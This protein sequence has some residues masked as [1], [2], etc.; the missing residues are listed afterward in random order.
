MLRSFKLAA[1]A[2]A[3]AAITSAPNAWAVTFNFQSDEAN[4][5]E[6]FYTNG[7]IDLTVTAVKNFGTS[8]D[9]GTISRAMGGLGVVG[10]PTAAN[11]G[12]NEALVF[13]FNP[14]VSLL[15]AIIFERGDEAEKFRIYDSNNV[16]I[17][18]F[19]VAAARGMSTQLFDL[20]GFNIV[21]S[22]FSIVGLEL[23]NGTRGGRIAQ[24]DV[25]AIPLP[26]SFLLLFG[27]LATL[28][29]VSVLR[30]RENT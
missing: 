30:R 18:D 25:A 24:I 27:G 21:G 3:V 15:N 14:A 23:G 11:L 5:S 10:A 9:A 2:L 4:V 16:A 26:A 29:T 28:G 1:V 8:N 12:L 20:T 19:T 6:A 17:T 7:S 13:S 22:S